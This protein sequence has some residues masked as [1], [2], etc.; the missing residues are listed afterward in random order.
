MQYLRTAFA[1]VAAYVLRFFRPSIDGILADFTRKIAQL[2]RVIDAANNEARAQIERRKQ[3]RVEIEQTYADEDAQWSIACRA[4]EVRNN[5]K[6][7][8]GA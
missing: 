8:I 6:E 4:S 3:L 7:M 2:E 5:L 1:A